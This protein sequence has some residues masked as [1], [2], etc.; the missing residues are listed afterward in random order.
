MLASRKKA[1]IDRYNRK[2]ILYGSTW[3]STVNDQV[4][5]EAEQAVED[6]ASPR[7]SDFVLDI[8]TGRRARYL[9]VFGR[10]SSIAVGLDISEM[11]IS[12][13]RDY[14]QRANLSCPWHLIVGS[15]DGLPFH[16]ESFSLV[17]C[18]ELMEYYSIEECRNI[19]GEIYRVLRKDGRSV[20]DFPDH[21]DRQTWRLKSAEEADGVSFF[22]Y[23]TM[24]ITGEINGSGFAIV[25]SQK[26]DVE[27]QYLLQ[28]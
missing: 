7:S 21:E 3:P 13:A 2:A 14:L 10:F 26:V 12:V 20:I 11:S 8:G 28:R 25:K 24:K 15:A 22:V 1:L 18:S 17:I 9:S 27:I 19:L 4:T 16:D 6:L 5:E 23:P